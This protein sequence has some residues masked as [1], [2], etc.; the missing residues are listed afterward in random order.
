MK[1]IVRSVLKILAGILVIAV[2][3]FG[4]LYLVFNVP[5]PEGKEGAKADDLAKQMLRAIHLKQYQQTRFLEWSFAGGAHCYKWDKTMGTVVVS[6][7]DYV[8]RLDLNASKNSNVKHQG[9]TVKGRKR[10]RAIRKAQDFFNNDSFWL[11]APYKVFDKG[12]TRSIVPLE[13]GTEGLLVRYSMG[14]ST[15]GDCYLW[16]LNENGFPESYR[17]WV[18][19]IP[20]GGIEASWDDWKMMPNGVYLPQSHSIGPINLDMGTLKAYN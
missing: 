3:G 6:W 8:V 5:V 20:I 19:I 16:E 14:G 11:V 12:T 1:K 10:Q 15:P 9:E 13:D 2:V 4:L 18:S 17:M 7:S